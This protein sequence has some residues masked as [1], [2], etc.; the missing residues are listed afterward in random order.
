MSASTFPFSKNFIA[1]G[2]G[3]NYS[4]ALIISEF[5]LNALTANNADADIAARETIFQTL[6]NN[7]VAADVSKD[8]AVGGR[9]T[10]TA[11]LEDQFKT[12]RTEELPLWQTM[13]SNVYPRRSATFKGLFPAG[14]DT[15]L[16]GKID[17]KIEAM[18]TLA[19]ATL[20]K[21]TLNAVSA[22]ITT[23]YNALLAKRNAQLGKKSTISGLTGAQRAAI[24]AMCSAHFCDHGIVISKYYDN[25]SK[26]ES[27]IDVIN[28]QR[29]PHSSTY[30]GTVHGSKI[31]TALK[32][33]F[34]TSSL[35][36]VT[37]SQDC[38]V[39]VI[40]S[41]KNP[42]KPTGVNVPANVPTIITF[43]EAGNW[44]HRVVQI[45]NMTT[46]SASYTMEF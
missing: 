11:S 25:P 44:A 15:I 31:K 40:D 26:I 23:R 41:A 1:N 2:V 27:F 8:V 3:D 14:T 32:H 4:K 17:V 12:I 9:I 46:I 24:A 20:A 6:H 36:T 42:L 28:L 33:N 34:T 45:K 18:K 35:F 19:A 43:P 22:L 16:K 38:K 37:A 10:D 5:H 30:T 29:H 13:I 39:W 7:L 21:G